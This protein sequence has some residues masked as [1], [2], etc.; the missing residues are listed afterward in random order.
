MQDAYIGLRSLTY[1]Q[2]AARFLTGL[3][4]PAN[5]ARA[6]WSGG[7]CAYALRLRR[8]DLETALERLREAGFAP[9]RIWLRERDGTLR[10]AAP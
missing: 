1:A 8:G 3:G 7:G 4:M 5:A 6:P 10:E 2:R 9:G